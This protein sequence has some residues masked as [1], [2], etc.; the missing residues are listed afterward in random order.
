MTDDVLGLTT[1]PVSRQASGDSFRC[2]TSL[3]SCIISLVSGEASVRRDGKKLEVFQ[4]TIVPDSIDVVDLMPAWDGS[5][6]GCPDGTVEQGSAAVVV[7]ASLLV[8]EPNFA[9]PFHV[10]RCFGR[11]GISVTL[12][13][14]IVSPNWR[15]SA[16]TH[17]HCCVHTGCSAVTRTLP[18]GVITRRTFWPFFVRPACVT[19][20][21]P[22][23]VRASSPGRT[24]STGI[25]PRRSLISSPWAT[26][27]SS[28]HA[29]AA[30]YP[31]P[32]SASSAPSQ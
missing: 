11:D 13:E 9:V 21:Q 23:R 15:S 24:S 12:H 5:V 6:H 2:L 18:S 17:P 8:V 22:R 26:Q 25:S 29:P 28:S 31:R 4:P 14:T 10:R 3:P 32:T 30:L 1:S 19:L 27:I 20:R 7:V 16:C